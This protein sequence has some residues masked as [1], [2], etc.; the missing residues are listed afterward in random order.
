VVLWMNKKKTE[1]NIENT[2]TTMGNCCAR[3]C[4]RSQED[5]YEHSTYENTPEWTFEGVHAIV[6]VVRIVD[7]DTVDIAFQ[8]PRSKQIY[9]HRVRLYGIDTPEKRPRKDHPQREKEIDASKK[10]TDALRQKLKE[11]SY[12][13]LAQFHKKDK[14]GRELCTFYTSKGDQ[15]N[16][17]MIQHGYAEP[18]DGGTKTIVIYD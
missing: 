6:K 17:W 18:Y 12:L 5:P 1:E 7:G 13:V 15:I 16:E 8:H 4:S 14:Y 9:R 11:E 2:R 10:A 3:L